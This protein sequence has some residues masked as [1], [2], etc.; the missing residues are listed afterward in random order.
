M[1]L[2]CR[3]VQIYQQLMTC[4]FIIIIFIYW[5]KEHGV[6]AYEQQTLKN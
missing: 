4:S 3:F 2:E 1:I 6:A 5:R